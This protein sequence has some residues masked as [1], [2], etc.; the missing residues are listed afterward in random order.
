M[1]NWT[2]NN[3]Y[4][5]ETKIFKARSMSLDIKMQKRGK[6]SNGICIGCGINNETGEE[7]IF[8]SGYEE[9]SDLGGKPI[10]Y[11]KFYYGTTSEMAIIA[12]L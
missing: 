11:S 5:K 7:I 12:K 3:M 6:Y 10:L 4:Q 8:C 9:T 2:F 1:K